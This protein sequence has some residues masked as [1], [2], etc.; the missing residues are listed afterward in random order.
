MM[1]YLNTDQDS[2][3][4]LSSRALGGSRPTRSTS[5][6]LSS[7]Q[8]IE[9]EI[10]RIPSEDFSFKPIQSILGQESEQWSYHYLLKEGAVARM[11][12]P[13]ARSR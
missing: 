8:C 11:L 10:S 5:P 4:S 3:R 7:L 12:N 9:N 1:M 2:S 13:L 6:P